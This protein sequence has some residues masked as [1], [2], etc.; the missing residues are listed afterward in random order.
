[1][2]TKLETNVGTPV[3]VSQFIDDK[4]FVV[5]GGGGQGKHGIVNKLQLLEA[6]H[7]S[8]KEIDE[9]VFPEGS[10]CPTAIS[11]Y[12][13]TITVGCNVP[14]GDSLDRV[15][16]FRVEE[17]KLEKSFSL[18]TYKS[19][20]ATVFQR[21]VSKNGNMTIVASS[22]TPGKVFVLQNK[23]TEEKE[24]VEKTKSDSDF[25]IT[26]IEIES[27]I[28]QVILSGET[29][30]IL[31]ETTLFVHLPN[32]KVEE[33]K[34]P[35]NQ[36][37]SRM[38]VIEE[39]DASNLVLASTV[40]LREG[41][42]LTSIQL[43]PGLQQLKSTSVPTF[44]AASA[45]TAANKLVVVANAKGDV[46]VYT[47][48]LKLACKLTK[49]HKLPV[50]SLAVSSDG[51]SV[52][53]TSM[54]GSIVVHVNI[55][56]GEESVSNKIA[57]LSLV[58]FLFSVFALFIQKHLKISEQLDLLTRKK[59]NFDSSYRP[60]LAQ[61]DEIARARGMR[62]EEVAEGLSDRENQRAERAQYAQYIQG[63]VHIAQDGVPENNEAHHEPNQEWQQ[64]FKLQNEDAD[65]NELGNVDNAFV[66]DD[67]I[68]FEEAQEAAQKLY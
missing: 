34:P 20:D 55:V 22:A 5:G 57:I 43:A 65:I 6:S 19:E 51:K 11:V 25:D 42:I 17:N 29:L 53:S 63:S 68:T 50:T 40:G 52:V 46:F 16:E 2:I 58:V 15:H 26:S 35:K 32:K 56:V 64:D 49:V 66:E 9:Y 62:L 67:H 36:K 12:N 31:T 7:S 23:H 28:L 41:V 45:L 4:Q 18:E 21:S 44:K 61:M 1:M 10:D 13:K 27:E 47:T 39:E 33:L 54:D 38:T 59:Q 3:Y 24:A 30:C 8:V 14:N 48:S 60:H 37:W